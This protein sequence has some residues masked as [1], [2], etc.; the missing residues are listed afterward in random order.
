MGEGQGEG[1]HPQNLITRI[2]LVVLDGTLI[3]RREEQHPFVT[4]HLCQV[5]V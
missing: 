3:R 2:L 1:L 4:H 5:V